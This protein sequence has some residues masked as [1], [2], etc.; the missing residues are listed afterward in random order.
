MC[1]VF[2]SSY[3]SGISNSNS[4]SFQIFSYLCNKWKLLIM[5]KTIEELEKENKELRK[6]KSVLTKYFSLRERG[7]LDEDNLKGKKKRI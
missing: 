7:I 3:N 2:L 1:N 4:K 5:R 6:V